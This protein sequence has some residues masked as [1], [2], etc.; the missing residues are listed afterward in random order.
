[1]ALKALMPF[2]ADKFYSVVVFSDKSEFKTPPIENV[3]HL[4]QLIGCI[5]RYTEEKLSQTDIQLIIGKL[6]YACQTIDITASE[7][8]ANL[9]AHQLA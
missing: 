1:M 7:H 2:A 6:S 4:N 9:Q 3:L 5:K 8:V